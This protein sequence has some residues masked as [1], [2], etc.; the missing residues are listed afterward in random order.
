MSEQI[1]S[2][3]RTMQ[4][5]GYRSF[6][7]NLM[8][9]VDPGTV[10][11]IRM[12]QLRALAKQLRSHPDLECFLRQ[13]PHE[14]YEENNLHAL[15]ISQMQDYACCIKELDRFLPYV[16]NWATC[17]SLR[18][19]CF[20]KHTDLLLAPIKHWLTS[21]K[22][23]AVRF[24]IEMLMV[25][26][27]TDKFDCCYPAMVAAIK[28]DDYYINMMIAWYF[29]TALAMQYDSVIFYLEQRVLE[30]WVHNK[31]IQKALESYRVPADLKSYLRQ[32]KLSR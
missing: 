9:T 10:L 25:H 17:D 20:S 15:F 4:D 29:A 18:P 26:Y 3:L 30:P 2:L 8:P 5:A 14:F 6:Q 27:L 7:C 28:S 13:L 12:P 24:A 22:T 21:E 32:L 1:K 11:G 31:T 19:K 16:D 23:Y